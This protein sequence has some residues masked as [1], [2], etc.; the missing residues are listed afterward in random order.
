MTLNDENRN[1]RTAQKG[2][3]WIDLK[4]RTVAKVDDMKEALRRTSRFIYSVWPS[5][6]YNYPVTYFQFSLSPIYY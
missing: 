4:P 6:V 2:K 3:R 5:A 1:A